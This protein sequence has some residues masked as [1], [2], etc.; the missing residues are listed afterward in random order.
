MII[1]KQFSQA[2]KE[3]NIHCIAHCTVRTAHFKQTKLQV[4]KSAIYILKKIQ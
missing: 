3:A 2:V 4:N 1:Y